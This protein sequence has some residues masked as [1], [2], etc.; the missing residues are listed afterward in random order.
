[1]NYRKIWINANGPIPRDKHGRVHE[2]HHIDG[3]R[4][5]NNLDNLMCLSIEDHFKKHLEQGDKAAAYRIGQRMKLDPEYL[6]QLNR[7]KSLGKKPSAES[8]KKQLE[9]KLKNG[10]FRRTEETKQKIS[11]GKKGKSNGHEGMRHREEW[12]RKQ[13]DSS[14]HP[15]KHM[16]TGQVFN[17][18]QEAANFFK[19]PYS[20]FYMRFKK[21]EFQKLR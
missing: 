20:T 1:M 17:S 18:I 10:T 4:S 15:C 2:I 7:E 12:K 8:I 3:N 21:G 16:E 13:S 5:N 11:E 14:K 6:R 9:T 19:Y